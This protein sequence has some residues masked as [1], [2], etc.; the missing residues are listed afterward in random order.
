MN[1][2][3]KSKNIGLE[4]LQPVINDLIA[5]ERIFREAP[6]GDV[7]LWNYMIVKMGKKLPIDISTLYFINRFLRR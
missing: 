2:K 1:Q 3:I 7:V 4:N 5:A 6:Q